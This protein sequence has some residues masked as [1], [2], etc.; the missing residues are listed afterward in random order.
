MSC[1]ER[2]SA[3]H[4]FQLQVKSFIHVPKFSK[5][6]SVKA[7]P[8]SINQAIICVCVCVFWISGWE[9]SRR[10]ACSFTHRPSASASP[11]YSPSTPS[12]ASCLMAATPIHVI[13]CSHCIVCSHLSWR[14]AC[15]LPDCCFENQNDSSG[16]S[17]FFP[18]SHSF[19]HFIFSH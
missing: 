17:S 5:S 19:S 1:V 6:L 7:N 4:T 13:I 11:F 10:K 15:R 3:N 16:A 12:V 18:L 14:W 8:V 9:W 2:R